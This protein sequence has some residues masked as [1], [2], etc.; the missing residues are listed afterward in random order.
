VVKITNYGGTVVSIPAPDRKKKIDDVVLGF[1]NLNDYLTKA[2]SAYYGALIGRYGNRLAKGTFTLDGKQYHIP[3]NDHGNSLH[4][5]NVG[6]NARVWDAKDVSGAHGQALE[7]TYLSPDGEE[8]YPGNLTVTVR[9][10]LTNK[11]EL[12]IDYTATTDKDTVIN[13]TN[14][15]YFNLA[16]KGSKSL[17][18]HKLTLNAD[19]YTPVDG[20][21]IPTGAIDNVAGTPFDFRKATTIGA[22]INDD[23]EQLKLGKGYD[24]NFVLNHKGS[25]LTLA[26]K[27]EEPVSGRVMEVLTTQPGVQFYTGNFLDGNPFPYRSALCLETQHF[28]D[29]PNHPNFPSAELKPGQTFHST[30]MYR[31][32]VE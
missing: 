10:T 6:F 32:S 9:Y 13:L 15:S 3:T 1:D 21:L 8:G 11:N 4:G 18:D 24:H 17:L 27:V 5:G 20:T 12:R 31:F 22:H 26:A 25:A 28:P 7:L 14:H 29:S 19:R 23:N 2:K 30:T 16:G